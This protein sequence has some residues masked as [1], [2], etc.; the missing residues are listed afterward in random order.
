MSR[1]FVRGRVVLQSWVGWGRSTTGGRWGALASGAAQRLLVRDV[2]LRD[3]STLRL[4]APA[5]ADFGD[6]KAF[7]DGLSPE[8]RYFRFHGYGRTDAAARAEAEASGV[9]R[10]AL[11]GR[12]DGRVVAVASYDGLRE[13][14][15]AKAAFAVA[16]DA[17]QRHQIGTRM[18]EQLAAVGAERGIRRLRRGG[19]AGQVSRCWGCSRMQAWPCGAGGSFRRADC[20]A[21]YRADGGGAG[22]DR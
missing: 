12:H 19:S 6:M 18:L 10:L 3:G 17:V 22:A 4:Q 15:A 5:P 2:L 21:G 14:G 20:I 9:D 16:D 7:Y 8:S 1:T 13:P 11:L